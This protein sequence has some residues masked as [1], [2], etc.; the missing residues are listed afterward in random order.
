MG[1]LCTRSSRSFAAARALYKIVGNHDEALHDLSRSRRLRPPSWTALRLEYRG[2][3]AVPLPRSPGHDLLRAVQR[4]VG[5]LP[6]LFRQHAAHPQRPRDR[7]KAARSTAPSTASTL[8]PAAARSCPSSGTRTVPCS[9]PCPRSTRCGSGSSSSAATTPP[10]PPGPGRRS[11][12]SLPGTGASLPRLWEKDREDGPAK[13]PVQRADQHPLPVQLRAAPSASAGVTAIEIAG[14][15]IALV[16]WFDQSRGSKHM[17]E[18]GRPAERLGTTDYFRSRPQAGQ[19]S[20]RVRT[21]QAPGLGLARR[22]DFRRRRPLVGG[23]ARVQEIQ[24]VQ[25][26]VVVELQLLPVLDVHPV[27]SGE[28]EA[29]RGRESPANRICSRVSRAAPVPTARRGRAR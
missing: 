3:H 7:T 25:D 14:G 24:A 17:I 22:K 26:P 2:G 4:R 20:V 10:S 6:P 29:H 5:L 9:S 13:Q 19:T 15:E 16:H 8:S 18:E 11:K 27:D 1:G 12:R 28:T 21:D 23:C